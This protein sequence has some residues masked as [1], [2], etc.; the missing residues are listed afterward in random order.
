MAS[1]PRRLCAKYQVSQRVF[2]GM[3]PVQAAGGAHAGLVEAGHL[4]LGR[5]I[6]DERIDRFFAAGSNR[7]R[8]SPGRPY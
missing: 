1:C 5:Q 7:R 4:G 8:S 3:Q 6:A 2:D